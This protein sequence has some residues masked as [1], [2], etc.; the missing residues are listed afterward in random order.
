MRQGR[1][2]QSIVAEPHRLSSA[3]GDRTAGHRSTANA[4]GAAT[5]PAAAARCTVL[6]QNRWPSAWLSAGT[7]STAPV[8]IRTSTT[9]A[10]DQCR[11][12]SVPDARVRVVAPRLPVTGARRLDRGHPPEPLH[13]LVAVVEG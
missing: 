7:Y 12:A 9:P 1:T 11:A 13:A 5:S 2:N 6:T 4:A 8:P 3:S 10:S